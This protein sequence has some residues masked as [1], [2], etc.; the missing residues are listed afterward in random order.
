MCYTQ[1]NLLSDKICPIRPSKIDCGGQKSKALN[2][3]IK[4]NKNTPLSISAEHFYSVVAY[5]IPKQMSRIRDKDC[6]FRR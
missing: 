5:I 6:R 3:K 2:D 4:L 1:V